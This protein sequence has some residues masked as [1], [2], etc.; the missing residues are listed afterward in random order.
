MFVAGVRNAVVPVE[1]GGEKV[2]LFGCRRAVPGT[3]ERMV[4]YK[5]VPVTVADMRRTIISLD[6]I[7]CLLCDRI[8]QV[9]DTGRQRVKGHIARQVLLAKARGLGVR[10]HYAR[11]SQPRLD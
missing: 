8:F 2:L 4:M 9:G 6:M 7:V 3:A 10:W 11:L 1:K 5:D